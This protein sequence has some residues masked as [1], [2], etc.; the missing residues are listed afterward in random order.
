MAKDVSA[1]QK[2]ACAVTIAVAA[3]LM[4]FTFC[5][6]FF[7]SW[8]KEVANFFVGSFGMAFYGIMIAA[9]VI[10]SFSLAGKKIQ[11]PKKYVAHFVLMFVEIVLLVH[12]F[13]TLFIYNASET[14]A[15]YANYV[16]HYYSWIPTFGGIV[17]GTI[18]YGLQRVITIY[19]TAVLLF[20]LLVWSVIMMGDFF[21]SYF[22]GRLSLKHESKPKSAAAPV[23]PEVAQPVHDDEKVQGDDDDDLR[24][25]AY[26]ILFTPTERSL[27]SEDAAPTEVYGT[28]PQSKLDNNSQPSQRDRAV[29]ILFNNVDV[30]ETDYQINT[31]DSNNSFNE[32][33]G[34][35]SYFGQQPAKQQ[36][37]P[38]I[39]PWRISSSTEETTERQPDVTSFTPTPTSSST[40]PTQEDRP[41]RKVKTRT[42]ITED[43]NGGEWITPVEVPQDDDS[44][45]DAVDLF[46]EDSASKT[47]QHR[48]ETVVA[49]N[50][51]QATDFSE[52]GEDQTASFGTPTVAE[53]QPAVA[54]IEE[55]DA[56]DEKF[57]LNETEDDDSNELVAVE[58]GR[59][60]HSGIQMGYDFKTKDDVRSAE[61]KI[62]KYPKYVKPPFDLLEKSVDVED[63]EQAYR[64]Q[65]AQSIVQKLAV[66]GIKVES[67]DQVV[68]PSVTRY[69]F[70]V[71]SE[72]TR[73]SDFN[74][75]SSD[76]KACLEAANDIIIQA[77]IAGTNLVGVE[78]AN[79]VV[80]TVKLRNLLESKEFQ[81]SNAK[82]AFIIGQEITGEIVVGDLSKLPHLLV[83][84][85][86]GS[87]KSVFLDSMIISLM[88]KY[89]PEYLRFIMVDPKL[90]ELS[91][92]N[93][94]PHMLTSETVTNAAE[95]LASM[96][97]LIKEMESRYQLFRQNGVVNIVGYNAKINPKLQQRLP[98]LVL[99]VDE[100]S[101]LMSVCQKQFEAK[102]LRLAQK[103]RAAGIHMVLATQRPDVRTITGTIKTNFSCRVAL[104]VASPQDSMTIL[105]TG[106]AEKLL[107]KGDMLYLGEGQ[108][109]ATRVQGTYV[110]D[111]EIA[112]FV[113]YVKESNELYFDENIAKE[114]FV[115][116]QPEEEEKPK[117]SAESQEEKL[118]P[119][120]KKA[121]RFWLE[122]QNGRASIASIQRSLKIGFNR[123]GRIMDSL[124]RLHYVEEVPS[125]ETSSRPVKVL[126]TLEELDNLFPD[127]ED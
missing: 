28:A 68:G 72:R 39:L 61:E 30:D 96:D 94:I 4:I 63:N 97:Y 26:K 14:Y 93:G 44:E 5:G 86:T 113:N 87:G 64:E 123:A 58:T 118:D 31:D 104:K 54:S 80:H 53:E 111:K 41:V 62:H 40:T 8:I 42:I 106:G 16:Y 37:Q 85:T 116:E 9:I 75:Y 38:D 125:N 15:E 48:Q 120:C 81:E 66:F 17:F 110:D 69:S 82:L 99:V 33:M 92:F 83:A 2:I 27:H 35:G 36:E 77:P 10:A 23:A 127:M 95:A 114:I 70:K 47:E 78:V 20:G 12:M 1:R 25:R 19:A 21:Y 101:D 74:R 71:L 24:S 107:G 117:E 73:M 121:L 84:G 51:T 115:S 100:L 89:G 3:V 105:S 13:S 76:I 119:Y 98:Y 103:S 59:A 56:S 45:I 122:R 34:G 52:S 6:R 67:V 126:V 29:D 43:S 7:N 60:A 102:L 22:T 112:D 109:A 18:V 90:V 32:E 50:N 65:A 79:K 124:Q 88:Y 55:K 108:A 91:R 49:E 57:S 11:I 46:V